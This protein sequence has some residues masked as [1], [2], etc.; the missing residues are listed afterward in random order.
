MKNEFISLFE[1]FR[2]MAV[3]YSAASLRADTHVPEATI[4]DSSPYA[5]A[6]G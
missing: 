6:Y 4:L 1:I 2:R 5:A 3:D